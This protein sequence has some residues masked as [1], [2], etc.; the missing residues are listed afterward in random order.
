MKKRIL[1]LLLLLCML[2]P[3]VVACKK[4]GAAEET[5]ASTDAATAG[6][7]DVATESETKDKYAVYDALGEID[8]GG[9]EITVGTCEDPWFAGEFTV[10]GY[11]GEIVNDAVYTRNFNV[12]NRLN[13]KLKNDVIKGTVYA[14]P[15]AVFKNLQ[16]NQHVHDLLIAPVYTTII[17]TGK[18]CWKDLT[19][20]SSLDLSQPYWSQWI[21]EQLSVADHQ[22]VATGA[23]ALSFY[24]QTYVTLVN[25]TM[26]ATKTDA[27]N[28]FEVVNDKKWTLEYQTLLARQ[29]GA[30]DGDG[31]KEKDDIFGFITAS[32]NGVNPYWSSCELPMLSKTQD[33]Y[34]QYAMNKDRL[35]RATDQ[36]ITLF[37]DPA[38]WCSNQRGNFDEVAKKFADGSALMATV[39]LSAVELPEV[40]NMAN[41]YSI[42]PI[43]KLDEDQETYFS[44]VH[45]RFSVMAIPATSTAADGDVFSI[46]MEALASESYRTVTQ[47]Y[48]E[49]ALKGRYANAES[50]KMIDMI[51]QNVYL[52][53]GVA[54]VNR[55]D[56]MAKLVREIV[57]S[58]VKN[59]TGNT[60]SSVYNAEWEENCRK[61][62]AR[63]N[64][65]LKQTIEV[66]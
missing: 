57:D 4:D 34:Y 12:E 66:S 56:N 50:V 42:L 55:I 8:L 25:D 5:A 2:L 18:G 7:S 60:V 1:C 21:N 16:S 10:E 41:E 47:T 6:G 48:Y 37:T 64:A 43:P 17:N 11:T 65:D 26:L 19:K 52:D 40:Q 58:A 3:T 49:K 63:L 51:T 29:Y 22:F 30:D 62:V 23:I 20:F 13:I 61:N 32:Y 38:T 27:P 31:V 24:R 39:M 9:R 28:L 44:F 46:V 45:D 54:Y 15:D 53:A 14:P 33:G 36:M 35:S 59:G